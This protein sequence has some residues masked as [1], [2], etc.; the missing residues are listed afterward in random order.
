[1]LRQTIGKKIIFSIVLIALVMTLCTFFI[2]DWFANESTKKVYTKTKKELIQLFENR[3]KSKVDI[4]VSNAIALSSNADLKLAL[5]ESDKDLAYE[6]FSSVDANYKENTRHKNIKIQ[7][8]SSS[9]KSFLRVWDPYE[10]ESRERSKI[11]YNIKEVIAT[12]KIISGFEKTVYGLNVHSIV[13]IIESDTYLGSLEFIQGI[14]L[15]AK[16]FNESNEGILLLTDDTNTIDSNIMKQWE[17]YTFSQT[18]VNKAFFNDLHNINIKQLLNKA[19]LLSDQYFYTHKKI[20]NSQNQIIGFVILGRPLNIVNQAID[21]AKKLIDIALLLTSLLI[22]FI[23]IAVIILLKRIVIAPLKEFENGL[24]KFFD[25]LGQKD[26]TISVPLINITTEDEIAVMSNAINENIVKIKHLVE[27][28]HAFINDVKRIV[29]QVKAGQFKQT[30][31]SSTS[32]ASLQELKTMLNDM[33]DNISNSI[34]EDITEVLKVFEEY[35]QLNFKHKI[36]HTNGKLVSEINALITVICNILVQNRSNGV[37][38]SDFSNKLSHNIK[39]LH[40]ASTEMATSLQESVESLNKI[41]QNST[42]N[43]NNVSVMINQANDV[44]IAVQ[45]GDDLANKT[46]LAMDDIN[47]QV[48]AINEGIGIIDEIAFQTNILSLNAAV[49]AATAG[50]AGK[51]FAVVAQEVRN[52]ASRSAQAADE[53]KNLVQHAQAKTDDGKRIANNM[54]KGYINLN[55]N[56]SKTLNVI[57]DVESSSKE[58]QKEISQ[59]N[60]MVS[61]IDQQTQHNIDIANKTKKIA[62]K[63]QQLANTILNDVNKIEIQP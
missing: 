42:A 36:S 1:M 18:F 63:S 16:T 37:I 48:R 25:Y 51:G 39:K 52:L 8:H 33:L 20:K 31:H 23:V 21:N 60:N 58:Q 53:I 61:K 34:C 30:V 55:D 11:H 35:N 2:L 41:S 47:E 9:G 27:E 40:E 22:L 32:N 13:P 57:K 7:V 4:G 12:K 17:K 6:I 3:V 24:M 10:N 43:I 45:K 46:N 44:Q 50:E 38:L 26:Q 19:F 54:I 14:E 49:E 59:I 56:I 62:I 5:D 28:D 15:I 29:L